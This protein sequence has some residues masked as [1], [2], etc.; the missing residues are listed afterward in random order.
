MPLLVEEIRIFGSWVT[1]SHDLGDID[2][3]VDFQRRYGIE[4]HIELTEILV[5]RDGYE[6][7]FFD[8]LCYDAVAAR[9]KLKGRDWRISVH[10]RG[11]THRSRCR[12]PANIQ[13]RRNFSRKPAAMTD[14]QH[15]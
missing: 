8:R 2:L 9:R 5:E 13:G 12:K 4:Y 7:S 6:G 11:G 14:I 15:N 10:D 3:A 1:G